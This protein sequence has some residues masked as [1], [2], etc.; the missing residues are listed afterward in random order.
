MASIILLTMLLLLQD[1]VGFVLP[2]DYLKMCC[3]LGGS[4]AEQRMS[5]KDFVGPVLD[6][7]LGEQP[8]CLESVETCCRK[9]YQEEACIRGRID[10][11]TGAACE[12]PDNPDEYR[13]N[14]CEGCKLGILTGSSGKDCAPKKFSR[15][16]LWEWIFI[17]CCNEA[18]ST[19]T[20]SSS[21]ATIITDRSP[22]TRDFMEAT[23]KSEDIDNGIDKKVDLVSSIYFK[24]DN[25][26]LLLSG[27]PCS[28]I[29]VRIPGSYY[30]QCYK[31]FILEEDGRSCKLNN[32]MDEEQNTTIV[33]N[34]SVLSITSTSFFHRNFSSTTP[35][36]LIFDSTLPLNLTASSDM[37]TSMK[38]TF[39]NVSSSIKSIELSLNT[40]IARASLFPSKLSTFATEIKSKWAIPSADAFKIFAIDAKLR[41]TRSL[42]IEDNELNLPCPTGYRFTLSTE[43]CDDIDECNELPIPVCPP[44][45]G[46][47]NINGTYRCLGPE[48]RSGA[49]EQCEFGYRWNSTQE[50]CVDVNECLENIHKCLMDAENCRN[51]DGSYECEVKCK[52]GFIFNGN[53]GACLDINECTDLTNVCLQPHTICVN[54]LGSF[55]CRSLKEYEHNKEPNNIGNG[56]D[57][58]QSSDYDGFDEGRD[59]NECQVRVQPCASGEICRNTAGGYDCIPGGCPRGFIPA[60]DACQD[61]DECEIGLHSCSTHER[62]QNTNG[63]FTCEQPRSKPR[64]PIIESPNLLC[65]KGYKADKVSGSCVDIDEC[66]E[67]PGC[68]DHERCRNLHGSYDCSPLCGPGWYFQLQTKTCQDVD[69]CLLG[70]HNCRQRT[71]YCRN[72]NGSYACETLSACPNGYRRDQNGSCADVDEC[73]EGV[74]TCSRDS[75]RY[76]VNRE[77]GYECI[78]RLPSCSRGFEYSLFT[79]QCED[80]DECRSGRASCEVRLNERCVNLPGSYRCERPQPG[81]RAHRQRPACP[82][83]HTYDVAQRKCSGKGHLIKKNSSSKDIDECADGTHNCGKQKCYNLPGSFQCAKAPL[84]IIRRKP[85]FSSTAAI[86]SIRDD[87]CDIGTRYDVIRGGCVDVNECEEIDD[88]CSS[89]EECRNTPG[90]FHCVCILGFRRDELTQACVDVNECQLEND[91]LSSQRCDNT[92]GSYTCVRFLPCGTGYT[93]NA[94]TEICED[95]DECS[96]GTH[97]CG[98]GYSCRN[99]HGSYRCD[100]NRIRT[101]STQR[102]T[103]KRSRRPT[104]RPTSA[105]I[106]STPRIINTNASTT[107]IMTSSKP[108]TLSI[109]RAIVTTTTTARPMTTVSTTHQ[110]NTTISSTTTPTTAT[111]MPTVLTSND[112]ITT[113]T[114]KNIFTHKPK[115]I[116]ITTT[117]TTED[118][119][120]VGTLRTTPYTIKSIIPLRLKIKCLRG[121]EN[122]PFGQCIDIDECHKNVNICGRQR[123]IN[124]IGS[125]RCEI[126]KICGIGYAADPITSQCKDINECVQGLHK[127]GPEQTCENRQG[128][129]ICYCPAGYEVGG[130]HNCI[131]LDE[132]ERSLPRRLCDEGGHCVNTLGSYRC[133]CDFGFEEEHQSGGCRDVDECAAEPGPCQQECYNTWGSYSCGCGPG[134]QLRPD[135]RTCEDIDECSEFKNTS[136]CVGICDNTPGSYVCRCPDGYRLTDDGRTCQDIDECAT[137]VVCKKQDEICQNVRGGFRCNKINCPP[138]YEHD[139]QRKNRCMPESPFCPI[140]DQACFQRPAYYTYNYISIVSLFPIPASTGELELFTMRGAY[141]LFDSTVNFSMAFIGASA[142]PHV[143]PATESCFALRKPYPAQA[144]L[145]LTQ[146]LEGPQDIELEFSMEVYG[147]SGNFAGSTSAKIFIVVTQYEF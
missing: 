30:C 42:P 75:H 84:P 139:L 12:S 115:K 136:L 143:K 120:T 37:L 101:T 110:H 34:P 14:C 107:T 47:Q 69:E 112:A 35:K 128:G 131:D 32:T 19:T 134:Y 142:P 13:R 39:S 45:S 5:C 105:A 132:C 63:S 60:G 87:N 50:R 18:I 36:P 57:D 29:C 100:R 82:S 9:A 48:S 93:L 106:Y 3:D 133:E 41:T 138:G 77:G 8:A 90:S 121:F 24:S 137:G 99:T 86:G 40:S 97:D 122:D 43:T 59:I 78:T 54:S 7:E 92:I 113:T 125:Y 46:C 61:V 68:R 96:L 31:G 130:S 23:L 135:N 79:R 2:N 94:A 38:S 44:G 83:G 27:M 1:A 28:Q 89:N 72:T 102:P 81:L 65:R 95:D 117:T 147:P 62:C 85:G 52:N 98:S 4:W 141:K 123:C 116:I 118:I 16:V 26:C 104:V 11:R 74:H 129:Y 111:S 55:E 66:V 73:L 64:T 88:A 22:A 58:R 51:L 124:T 114:Y 49:V 21:N 140:H 25:E 119:P 6:L 146:S 70:H 126:R 15:D 53:Y 76:C 56:S 145:V 127:C 103:I 20:R 91:C 17:K 109:Q 80:V 67:G 33:N 108:R 144:V 71:Q 10:A